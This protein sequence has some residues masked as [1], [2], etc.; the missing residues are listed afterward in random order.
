MARIS[1]TSEKSNSSSNPTKKYLDWKSN[2]KAFEFY[3]KEACKR[4]TVGLPLK[5]VFLQ[6]YHTVKGWHSASKSNIYSNEVFYI[7]SE[8]MTVRSFG[9][10]EE[11][12]PPVEIA[13]GIYTEMKLKINASGGKYHRS[14]Y[15]EA[16]S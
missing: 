14:V 1:H 5:F 12:L 11:K 7:G 15:V 16:G 10:K 13:S 3:D 6:H 2:S 4:V 9:N 8:P